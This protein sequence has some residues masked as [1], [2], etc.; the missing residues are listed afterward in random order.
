MTN[1]RPLRC[2]FFMDPWEDRWL[3]GDL[4]RDWWELMGSEGFRQMV[5]VNVFGMGLHLKGH[6]SRKWWCWERCSFVSTGGKVVFFSFFGSGVLFLGA[7]IEWKEFGDALRV[8]TNDRYPRSRVNC[9]SPNRYFW[10]GIW[11]K[12][13]MLTFRYINGK[14]SSFSFK[15]YQD[16]DM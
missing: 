11:M 10:V 13:L 16:Q 4:E 1:T 2:S 8:Q 15:P 12:G 7:S 6:T 3:P 9:E 14:C 5:G